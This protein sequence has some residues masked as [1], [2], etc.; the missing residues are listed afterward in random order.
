[1]K[2]KWIIALVILLSV[3]VVFAA[4]K[5]NDSDDTTTQPTTE[6]TTENVG[7]DIEV[8]PGDELILNEDALTDGNDI[9]IGGGS[10]DSSEEDGIEWS[11]IK[12]KNS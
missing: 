1:M 11:E 5:G 3:V 8:I 4:C 7:E 10:A 9:I 2:N 6:S 12:G